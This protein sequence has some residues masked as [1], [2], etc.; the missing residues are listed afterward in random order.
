M[1]RR[2]SDNAVELRYLPAALP[3]LY[4]VTVN[5]LPCGLF[6]GL[7][8]GAHKLDCP[9]NMTVL[10]QNVDPIFG[11]LRPPRTGNLS[12]TEIV[13]GLS[14]SGLE[15]KLKRG[16]DNRK[17]RDHTRQAAAWRCRSGGRMG[18]IRA[19]TNKPTRRIKLL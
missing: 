13:Y 5:E 8:V 16:G 10:V 2:G 17:A 4:V 15:T 19:A 12:S 14:G 18:W 1:V 6:R 7:V 11:H 9:A 3:K